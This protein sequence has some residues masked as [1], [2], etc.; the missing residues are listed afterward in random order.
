M[1]KLILT[2]CVLGIAVGAMAQGAVS[3][4]GLGSGVTV[5]T[6]VGNQTE[7]DSGLYSGGLTMQIFFLDHCHFR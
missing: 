6:G 1:K 3:G 7:F 5:S 2:T 4:F